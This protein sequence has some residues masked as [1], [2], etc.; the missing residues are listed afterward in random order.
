MA[1]KPGHKR[2]LSAIF[3]GNPSNSGVGAPGSLSQLQTQTA[4]QVATGGSG[5]PSPPATNSTASTGKESVPKRVRKTS[6]AF[7]TVKSMLTG[8]RREHQRERERERR[9]SEEDD[10]DDQPFEDEDH[11]ARLS[12]PTASTSSGGSLVLGRSTSVGARSTTSSGGLDRVR[13]LADRNRKVLDKLSSISSAASSRLN[14]PAPTDR[15]PLTAGALRSR[16]LS[17]MPPISNNT[18][19]PPQSAL[20]SGSSPRNGPI[21]LASPNLRHARDL[22]PETPSPVNRFSPAD[23]TGGSS[24]KGSDPQ[25]RPSTVARQGATPRM[26]EIEFKTDFE[27]PTAAKERERLYESQRGPIPAF[28]VSGEGSAS[29]IRREGSVRVSF[30]RSR[31]EV[32][33]DEV[34]GNGNVPRQRVY[35]SESD[36]RSTTPPADQYSRR[37][38]TDPVPPTPAVGR[39]RRVSITEPSANKEREPLRT[40]A[41]AG[42]LGRQ[43]NTSEAVIER[44]IA[45][46][47]KSPVRARGA[48]PSEFRSGTESKRAS[49]DNK[50]M[51]LDGKRTFSRSSNSPELL[52]RESAYTRP[53]TAGGSR[54]ATPPPTL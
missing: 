17:P 18:L 49:V 25:R 24:G 19:F 7:A 37:H 10:V 23:S 43:R 40:R 35:S 50:R 5:L 52:R 12:G 34:V 21:P 53:A 27:E 6:L 28:T 15:V 8:D 22:E 48:L 31:Q 29:G 32:E 20:S 33:V 54:S 41:A 1:S 45:A 3:L 51:S 39:G 44:T 42:T 13:N 30:S 47:R 26:R 4:L 11:T 46:A 9:R 2:P 14:S 36:D 16:D 38:V